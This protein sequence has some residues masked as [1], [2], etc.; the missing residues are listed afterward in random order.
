MTNAPSFASVAGCGRV[1]LVEDDPALLRSYARILESD[2]HAVTTARNGALALAQL[3]ESVCDAVVTDIAMPEMDGLEFLRTIRQ[4]ENTIPVILLTG[5]PSMRTAEQAIE[6]GAFRYVEKPIAMAQLSSMVGQ[7]VAHGQNLR[8]EREIVAQARLDET[9]VPNAELPRRFNAAMDGLRMAYQP[10]VQWSARS[11]FAHEAL[12]RTREPT[13]RNPLELL[14]AAEQL[15]E[16]RRLARAIRALVPAPMSRVS[17]HLF[18]NVAAKDL[19]DP[20]LFETDTPLAR[21]A[22]RTV[23]EITER[24]ALEAIDDV[25]GRIA[26]LRQLGYRIALDD[27]GAGYAGLSSLALLEPDVVKLDMSLVRGI[28][29]STTKQRLMRSMTTLC[30]GLGALVVAEGVET[31]AELNTVTALGCDYVQGYLFALPGEPFPTVSADFA[32][33]LRSVG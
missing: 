19:E 21:I 15:G 5:S 33:P 9:P 14:S 10:I 22:G 17:S 28:D 24:D 29:E 13:L 8:R 4:A 2:G 3:R 26:R 27:M 30:E 1:L 20:L 18:V 31:V 11:I 12:V 23:L 7:A 25:R 6:Y 32:V 16:S